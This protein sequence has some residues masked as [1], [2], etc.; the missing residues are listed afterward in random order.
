MLSVS[1]NP[2]FDLKYGIKLQS[3]MRETKV[4]FCTLRILHAVPYAAVSISFDAIM[5]SV[6]EALFFKAFL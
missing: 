5:Y 4:I 1:R 2:T 6:N 3:N